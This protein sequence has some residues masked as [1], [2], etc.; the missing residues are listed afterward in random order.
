MLSPRLLA[1]ASITSIFTNQ[2][3]PLTIPI[4]PLHVYFSGHTKLPA[5]LRYIHGQGRF[6][7]PADT[8][9]NLSLAT[10]AFI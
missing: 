7:Q 8:N 4:R 5:H 10:P 1:R 6:I 2:L 9:G 3:Y